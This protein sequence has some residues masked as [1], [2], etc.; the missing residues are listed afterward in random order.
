[1]AL[2]AG[3]DVP[4]NTGGMTSSLDPKRYFMGTTARWY[5]GGTKVI[6][7]EH[8]LDPRVVSAGVGF[9]I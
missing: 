2:Q 6:Q 4:V 7:T 9:R 3:L 5:A 1:M 8:T